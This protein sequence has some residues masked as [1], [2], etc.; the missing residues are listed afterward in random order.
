MFV[1]CLV[2]VGTLATPKSECPPDAVVTIGDKKSCTKYYLC[3]GGKPL[4]QKCATGLLYDHRSQKCMLEKDA[5]CT[6]D[7][8]PSDNFGVV[9][10]VVHPED[11]SKY[12]VCVRG[13]GMQL[14]CGKNLLYN[15]LTNTCDH[16]ANV[17][18]VSFSHLIISNCF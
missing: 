9:K 6:L 16:A 18:C 5:K 7:I 1:L 4:E 8:C 13:Q 11:C 10:M 2:V 14:Q 3:L 15:H 12:F 17:Y